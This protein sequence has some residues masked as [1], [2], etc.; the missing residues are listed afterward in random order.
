MWQDKTFL[1]AFAAA[2]LFW[3]LLYLLNDTRLALTWPL[4][5]PWQ[6]LWPAVFYPIAEE[7]AF[8]GLIQESVHQYVRPWHW[9]RI[10]LANVITSLL[11][12]GMHFFYH[13]PQW[14]AAVIIPSLVFGFFKD[15]YQS[16][17][18]PILLHLFY[19]AGYFWLFSA[20]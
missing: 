3:G 4:H 20:P 6:F 11:F 18:P 17:A 14:A 16:L 8:R 13:P 2:L 9:Q 15:K 1:A 10:S 19:N 7:I 5:Y 12:T